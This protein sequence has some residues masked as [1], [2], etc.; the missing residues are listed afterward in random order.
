[1]GKDKRKARHKGRRVSERQIFI[2]S[3]LGGAV[4][5]YLAMKFF[6]HKT[7]HKSFTYGIPL[8]ILIQILLFAIYF[9]NTSG[10]VW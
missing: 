1:M 9:Y 7:R 3:I 6:R 2:T 4:G 5:V 8:I 10:G